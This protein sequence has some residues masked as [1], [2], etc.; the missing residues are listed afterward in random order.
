MPSLF[1]RESLNKAASAP[2]GRLAEP[3]ATRVKEKRKIFV[4]SFPR[5]S[6][7]KAATAQQG[8]S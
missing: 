1:S 8:A 7:N 4:Q 3:D 5:E 2:A 6:L